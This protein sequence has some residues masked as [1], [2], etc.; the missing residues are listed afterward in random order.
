V[1]PLETKVA[2]PNCVFPLMNVTEPVG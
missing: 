1:L 2:L